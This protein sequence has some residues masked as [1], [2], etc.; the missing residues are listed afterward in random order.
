MELYL[1]LAFLPRQIARGPS[2]E[3]L[4]QIPRS[5]PGLQF[6]DIGGRCLVHGLLIDIAIIIASWKFAQNKRM[7]RGIL[8][9]RITGDPAPRR[10]RMELLD[11]PLVAKRI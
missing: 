10:Q 2:L 4:D 3:P 6:R 1:D 9:G 7:R 5:A 11:L 8:H